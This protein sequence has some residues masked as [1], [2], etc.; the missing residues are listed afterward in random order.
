M[1]HFLTKCII[2]IFSLLFIIPCSY[3]IYSYMNLKKESLMTI[4]KV[5]KSGK[6]QYLGCKPYIEFYDTEG[7]KI[8]IKS[9]INYHIFFCPKI[10][11]KIKILYKKNDPT[12][13]I[14]AGILHYFVIPGLFIMIGIYSI[15]SVFTKK[16][17]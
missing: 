5:V 14:V 16:I 3:K 11:D 17:R 1:G 9:A 7:S 12:N 8:E 10:G 15:Y 6:G 4:G 13:A 2:L